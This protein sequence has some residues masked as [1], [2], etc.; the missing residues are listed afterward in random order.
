MTTS[1]NSFAMV[2]IAGALT[3]LAAG[4]IL[5]ASLDSSTADALSAGFTADGFL[6][7]LPPVAQVHGSA[8][9]AYN[10]QIVLPVY[11]KILNIANRLAPPPELFV[12]LTGIDDHVMD[13]G[14]GIDNFSSEGDTKIATTALSLVFNPLPPTA[15]PPAQLLLGVTATAVQASADYSVVVPQ[16]P[17]VHATANFSELTITGALVGGKTLTFSGNPPVN[18]ILF[19]NSDV[20]ITLNEQIIVAT[21]VTCVVPQGCTVTPGGIHVKALHIVLTNANIFGRIVSGDVFLGEAQAGS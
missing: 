7:T 4:P 17:V 20:T 19:R 1:L 11:D 15:G 21:T 8:P 2:A 10:K 14:I 9:P 18:H 12:H 13:S 3:A 6:T 16:P 5:A